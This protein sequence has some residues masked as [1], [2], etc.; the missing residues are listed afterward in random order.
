MERN[1]NIPTI[2]AKIDKLSD[3]GKTRA[4]ASVVIGGA[5]AIHGIRVVDSDQGAFIAMP[6]DT[7]KTKNGEVKYQDRF[8]PVTAEARSALV[9]AV[10]DAYEQK[11]EQEPEMETPARSG[12]EMC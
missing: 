9:N 1:T 7:F 6:Q 8:H 10:M 4:F 5:F 2:S 11:L 3:S 12:M